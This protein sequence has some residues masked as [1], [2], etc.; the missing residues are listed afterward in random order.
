M[1]NRSLAAVF[2]LFLPLAAFGQEFRG[3]ISGAVTDPTG[4]A[5]AGA[6]VVATEVRTGTKVQTVSE[7]T[8][9]YT[10]PFL[11][12]GE[13]DLSTTFSGFKEFIRRGIQIGAGDHPVI[14]VRLSVGE[15]TTSVEVTADAPLLNTENAS[16]GQAI[17]TK[18]VEF[19]PLNGRTPRC[20]HSSP[21]AWWPPALRSWRI[22]STWAVPPRSA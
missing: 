19:L 17:T 8:G 14:D 6:K 18:E 21:W 15:A 16:T 2:C 5:V 13:Y 22:R 1:T 7:S 4:A 3:T 10:L 12:P 9:Q 20:S 11:A